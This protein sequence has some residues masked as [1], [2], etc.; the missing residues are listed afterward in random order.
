MVLFVSHSVMASTNLGQPLM[1]MWR[2]IYIH[3]F[4]C[5]CAFY[6]S[7]CFL[8]FCNSCICKTNLNSV[9]CLQSVWYNFRV[10]ILWSSCKPVFNINYMSCHQETSLFPLLTKHHFLVFNSVMCGFCNAYLH[11]DWFDPL[12]PSVY[13]VNAH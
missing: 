8:W 12:Q 4:F 7:V 11:F 10:D 6:I 3:P 13:S 9:N 2:F 5:V 1:T